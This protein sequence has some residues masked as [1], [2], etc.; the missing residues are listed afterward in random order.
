MQHNSLPYIIYVTSASRS[1]STLLE[2]ILGGAQ[3]S[4]S[5]GEMRRLQSLIKRS[6]ETSNLKTDQNLFLCSC[7]H[8]IDECEVWKAIERE[9]GLEFKR[10]SF[11]TQANR[12]W[13]R[14]IQATYLI[15][16]T[17]GVRLFSKLFMQ[18]DKELRIARNCLSVYMAICNI[19]SVKQIIDSSKLIY[20]YILLK[21]IA[22]NNIGLIVLY[23]DG[24]AVAKS[25]VRG[26][27]A[28]LWKKNGSIFSLAAKN[29]LRTNKST[30]L[31]ARKVPS[32]QKIEIRYEDFCRSPEKTLSRIGQHLNINIPE[33]VATALKDKRERHSIGGSPSRFDNS[34]EI[35]LDER[36]KS[37]ITKGEMKEFEKIA[38]RFNRMLGYE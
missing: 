20:H 4:F 31:F 19:Y 34:F 26:D 38:G 1:G 27:R 15:L 21:T 35:K 9:S 24:R 36:W 29:W 10:T 2:L 25:M 12:G 28:Q 30:R 8:Y 6:Y 7:G 33:N 17:R 14:A 23:R 32:S 13:R 3:S 11:D 18:F 5:V 37:S 16:G 22:P